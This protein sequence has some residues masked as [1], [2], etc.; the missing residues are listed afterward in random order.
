MVPRRGQRRGV[1]RN[2]HWHRVP[3]DPLRLRL[4][5]RVEGHRELH[6]LAEDPPGE[7]KLRA[8]KVN[9][10]TE[11]SMQIRA[12][13]EPVAL[14]RREA[15]QRSQVPRLGHKRRPRAGTPCC[16]GRW[17]GRGGTGAR[18]RAA[19]RLRGS[20]GARARA[21]TRRGRVGRHGGGSNRRRLLLQ[22]RQPAHV[23]RLRLAAVVEDNSKLDVLPQSPRLRQEPLVDEDVKPP[24]LEG[25]GTGQEP[26]A[27]LLT[28]AFEASDVVRDP[29]VMVHIVI[30]ATE[31]RALEARQLRY[32]LFRAGI[33]NSFE[34]GVFTGTGTAAAG[35]I[36]DCGGFLHRFLFPMI[37][38]CRLF[39]VFL[40]SFHL[41]SEP[42]GRSTG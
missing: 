29:R 27:V 17:S 40:L 21:G 8:L 34:S 33:V 36:A 42:L 30:R 7:R 6:C 41:S 3:V 31:Q 37:L 23:C 25:V 18:V 16:S 5:A 32:V 39:V 15:L 1:Q 11:L 9:I 19:L 26:I 24:L 20:G 38:S 2:Q 12:R 4:P 14:R 22:A 35:N 13:D 10:P 28:E